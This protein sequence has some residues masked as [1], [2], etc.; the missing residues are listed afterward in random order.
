MGS[1][2]TIINERAVVPNI[3][4]IETPASPGGTVVRSTTYLEPTVAL[5]RSRPLHSP[6]DKDSG[7]S[8]HLVLW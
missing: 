6:K 1:R 7:G 4:L 2:V 3:R 5:A 8:V